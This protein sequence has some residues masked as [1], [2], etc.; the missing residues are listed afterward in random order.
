MKEVRDAAF[1]LAR[2]GVGADVIDLRT[3]YPLDEEAIVA[4]VSKTGRILVIHEGPQSFGVAAE[5]VTLVSERA[6]EYLEAPPARLTGSDT[7]FPLPRSESRYMIGAESIR[8]EALRVLS[9]EP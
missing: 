2:E 3:I 1:L 4:S 7:V 9:Y 8:A 6:F 5:V